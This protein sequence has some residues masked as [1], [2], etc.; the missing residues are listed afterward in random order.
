MK[1]VEAEEKRL[2]D[3]KLPVEGSKND[4]DD[5][6]E[7]DDKASI[8]DGEIVSEDEDDPKDKTVIENVPNIENE[9]EIGENSSML[10]EST[11]ELFER[12]INRQIAE[13]T[14]EKEP[15][16]EPPTHDKD[17]SIGSARRKSSYEFEREVIY[18]SIFIYF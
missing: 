7:N 14:S 15:T 2:V 10:S 6:N 4:N 8:E 1:I 3:E 18:G 16:Q 13:V 12:K 11:T 5:K 17:Q 9:V